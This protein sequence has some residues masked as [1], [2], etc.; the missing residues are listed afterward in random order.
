MESIK[1]TQNSVIL[2]DDSNES[3]IDL[4]IENSNDNTL[5]DTSGNLIKFLR[6]VSSKILI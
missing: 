1:S 4:E 5:I 6:F 3:E 2:I